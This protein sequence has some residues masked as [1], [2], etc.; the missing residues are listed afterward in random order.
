VRRATV[1]VLGLT[2]AAFAL[3]LAYMLHSHPFIDEFT[4]VLAARAILERGLPLLPSGLFYEHG[5]LFSYVDA[6]FVALASEE[7]LF[8]VARLPSLLIGTAT[9]PLL[10]WIGRR[11][12]SPLTGLIA[13]ALLAL[14]PEGIV[15]GGRARMY[16][17]AQ[18]LVLLLVFL[19]Y[20]GTSG[21]GGPLP[22]VA[23]RRAR[24][25][26]LVTLLALLLTQFGALLLVPPL[27]VGALV[28]GWLTHPEGGRPWFTRGAAL[29]EAV[30]LVLVVGLGVL[31]K[32]LGR[33]LGSAPLEGGSAGGLIQ[34]LIGTIGYQAGLALDGE[35]TIDFLAR[36]FG[37]PHH[38]WLTL[39]AAVG[40]V[41]ALGLW[42]TVRRTPTRKAD[43]SHEQEWAAPYSL[44]Y[45]WLVFGLSVVEIV[46]LLEPWRRNPRYLVMAL[47][48]LYL[49][50][51]ASLQAI[52]YV[53]SG[54]QGIR[55]SGNQQAD[56]R[57]S[58]RYL[59]TILTFGVVQALLLVPD[60]QVAYRTPEPAYEEAF[61]YVSDRWQP[62]DILLTMNTSG[63]GL[64]LEDVDHSPAELGF[65]IQEGAQQFL[66][67]SDIQPVDR[68]LGVP[69]IGTAA[70]FNRA[71]NEHSRAWFVVDTIRLPVYYRGDWLVMVDSQM[72]LVWSQ[73]NALVYSTRPDR[74]PLPSTPGISLDVRFGDTLVLEGY[75]MA[76]RED[77]VTEIEAVPCQ[78]HHSLCLIPGDT[79]QVTLFWEALAPMDVDY[80][81]FLHLRNSQGET[82]AQRDSQPLD[83]LYPTSQWQVGE[84]ITQP[85][86][87]DLPLD[88]TPGPYALHMGLYRLDTMA[89]LS[90]GN[91]EN[92]EDALILDE[93]ILVV[94]GE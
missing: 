46:V 40:G 6:P 94:S 35:S 29:V 58:F 49:L 23:P 54:R 10:Y 65:A 48:L 21:K 4:T 93:S 77:V 30:G 62:G 17:L 31:V 69:W 24:W 85:L 64:F 28:V 76:R 60:L 86:D 55:E 81:V 13:A 38:V 1:A 87:V 84:E 72:D 15:W 68:W 36:Q 52:A 53:V 11:W 82:V 92:G 80:T 9:V 26:A 2:A 39:V 57:G 14:S 59:A 41:V 37:V 16:A 42:L 63:A 33:P 61:R 43:D 75:T 27:L 19:V 50:V 8:S 20:E 44:L 5:L 32:R 91:E 88:L 34:E 22:R 51:G 70:D 89:R 45:L 3:R 47:P 18:L 7:T 25:L 71:L 79:L 67:E 90:L 78:A 56:R 66:L 83:G 74:V 73:D 12:L